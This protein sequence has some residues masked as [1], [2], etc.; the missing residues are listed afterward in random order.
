MSAKENNNNL[1]YVKKRLGA[2]TAPKHDLRPSP[3]SRKIVIK[4]ESWREFEKMRAEVLT[5]IGPQTKIEDMLCEIII[6]S[7]WK[8]RRARVIERNLLNK[9]NEITFEEKH[10]SPWDP[11]PRER[12]RNID[13]V[14]MQTPEV[15]NIIKYQIDLEKGLQKALERIRR[16][17]SDRNKDGKHDKK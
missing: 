1:R 13:R 7:T 14:H 17:R 15:Q 3:L 16:I 9:E 2:L 4:G 8:V 6:S 12:I 10:P 5:E 11:K